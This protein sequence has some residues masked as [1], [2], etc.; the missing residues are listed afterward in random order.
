MKLY[1]SPNLFHL[2]AQQFLNYRWRLLLSSLVFIG[3]FILLQKQ[4]NSETPT[5]LIWL[6]LFILFAGLQLLIFSA[7]I[8]FF[9]Q[10]PSKSESLLHD[11]NRHFWFKLYKAVEWCEA[12]LFFVILPLPALIFFYALFVI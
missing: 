10:L 2:V 12:I 1:F 11:E 3:F 4:I 5:E 9:Q 8:F 7:F 6:A